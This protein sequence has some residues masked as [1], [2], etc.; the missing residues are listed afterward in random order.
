MP[1]AAEL[2]EYASAYVISYMSLYA[3][4]NDSSTIQNDPLSFQQWQSR[5]EILEFSG[6]LPQKPI[7]G[8]TEWKTLSRI[9]RYQ[10]RSAS[11]IPDLSVPVKKLKIF[12]PDFKKFIVHD[13]AVTMVKYQP[14]LKKVFTGSGWKPALSAFE[15]N[16]RLIYTSTKNSPPVD[17]DMMP[18]N[19]YLLTMLGDLLGNRPGEKIAEIS[20][21]NLQTGTTV[22]FISNLPRT[23]SSEISADGKKLCA[24]S[25][26]MM[27]DGLLSLYNVTDGWKKPQI[28]YNGSGSIG[29]FLSEN[30]IVALIADARERIELFHPSEKK[31]EFVIEFPPTEGL[32]S[33]QH[34][35]LNQ[36]GVDEL[37]VTN[38]DNA[39]SGPYNSIKPSHGL[40]IFQT[41]DNYKSL[42]RVYRQALPGAYGAVIADFN[43]DNQ[44]DILFF[45]H[46]SLPPYPDALILINNSS[47][48][49]INFEAYLIADMPEARYTIGQ[50]GDI[51]H[52]GD[53]DVI[54]GLSTLPETY[55]RGEKIQVR[56][57]EQYPSFVLFLENI[58]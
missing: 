3:G 47:R 45:S 46:F 49:K 9:F 31:S 27:G 8:S 58:K 12:K 56:K 33:M 1:D 6:K 25:F 5:K 17:L 35:D 30:N 39:D 20:K 43:G 41:S 54:L 29:C 18:D 7:I 38:G 24:A 23:A 10:S 48:E 11:E 40:Q 34:A 55:R 13:P 44:P 53:Q 2:D 19:T 50:A 22:P 26:G 21:L 16:G 14:K 51:D 37:I 57:F 52:D 4:I 42:Q 28:L 15:E 36:D 32:T